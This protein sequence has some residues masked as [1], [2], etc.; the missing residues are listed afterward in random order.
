MLSL[1]R[2][3]SIKERKAQGQ[4]IRQ[5]ARE[6]GQ[7]RN[8]IRKAL[9]QKVQVPRAKREVVSSLAP[10]EAYVR[11]RIEQYDLSSVRILDEIRS[12]GY[13]GSVATL[14]R[15]ARAQRV[16]RVNASKATVRFQSPPGKQGQ[17]DWLECGSI[18]TAEGPAKLYG[19]VMV[20]GYSRQ[21]FV[22]FTT[23]MKLS[24]LIRCHQQAFD[25]FGGWPSTL[26]YDNMK[27]VRIRPGKLNEGFVDFANH[28]GFAVKTCRPYR[29]RT[30]GKVERFID[31]VRENFL[32]GRRFADLE[33]LNAQARHWLDTV[34][35]VRIH[36]T[37]GER[38]CD[39]LAQETLIAV[40]SVAAYQSAQPVP[41]K[42]G[43]ESVVHFRGS[44]YSVPPSHIGSTV[45]VAEVG[46]L[47]TVHAGDMIV[48]EHRAA[49][50]P[51]QQIVDKEHLAALWQVVAAQTDEPDRPRWHFGGVPDVQVVP[52]DVYATVAA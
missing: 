32:A 26:L 45:V 12:M 1:E 38:P 13:R 21:G 39:L 42:V 47:V 36:A 49:I 11:E 28:H 7:S 52:L 9:G 4:S 2:W 48:A 44:R 17:V 8:T 51:G 34:A 46:G 41:R 27:T 19:F 29:P 30:K 18:D 24:M 16:G 23:S 43:N 20:L 35:N 6:T 15:F 25:Y 33:D 5:I 31:Y 3:M 10:F 50:R 14:R 40:T 22:V 37:T